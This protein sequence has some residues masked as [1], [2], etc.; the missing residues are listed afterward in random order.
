MRTLALIAV[1]ALFTA[2]RAPQAYADECEISIT[3]C[4][5]LEYASH[6]KAADEV[7]KRFGVSPDQKFDVDPIEQPFPC[8][9]VRAPAK[10]HKGIREFIKRFDAA[11]GPAS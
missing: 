11:P 5:T 9:L 8:V 6:E 4:Y 2:A 7:K 1:L 10:V 3:V